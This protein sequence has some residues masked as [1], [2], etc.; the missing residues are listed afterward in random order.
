MYT[1]A[2]LVMVIN[3]VLSYGIIANKHI[4]LVTITVANDA[5]Y[6]LP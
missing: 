2:K 3:N 6:I 5:L 1:G 4:A